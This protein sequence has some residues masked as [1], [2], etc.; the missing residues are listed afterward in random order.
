MSIAASTALKKIFF[1]VVFWPIGFPL[2]LTPDT[3]GL[4]MFRTVSCTVTIEIP[5]GNIK[6]CFDTK[7]LIVILFTYCLVDSSYEMKVRENTE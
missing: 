6:I 4:C 3:S 1:F 7:L 2:G 5:L